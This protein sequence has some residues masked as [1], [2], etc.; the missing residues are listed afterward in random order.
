MSIQTSKKVAL[1]ILD[2]WGYR[3]EKKYNAIAQAKTPNWDS[4]LSQ[5]SF[6]L[7][8]ASGSSVG[9]PAGQMGNSEVGHMH[10][11]S[12]QIIPQDLCRINQACQSDEFE[13]LVS[14]HISNF[15]PKS[16]H[17]VGLYSDGGVH[18]HSK[19]WQVLID[20]LKN[21]DVYLHPILDGRDTAPKVAQKDL[22]VLTEHCLENPRHSLATIS[23]RFY[24]MDRDNR[25]ER[26]DRYAELFDSNMKASQQSADAYIKMNYKQGITDEFIEPKKLKSFECHQ[27]DLIITMNFRPDRMKQIVT[28]LK[29]KCSVLNMTDYGMALPVI[30]EKLAI[31]SCLGSIFEQ[32]LMTQIRV[33]E[34]EK[35]P[36]VTYFFNA[37][38]QTPF[39]KEQRVLIPSPKVKTYDESPEMSADSVCEAIM[40]AMSDGVN[41]IFANFANADM[42]GHT[43]DFEK[44]VIAVEVLDHCI[45]QLLKQAKKYDYQL[46]IT[47]D[48][49]NAEWMKRLENDQVITSHTCS[50]VPFVTNT[51]KKLKNKGGLSDIAPT[52]LEMM[53]VAIPDFWQGKSLLLND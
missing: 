50:A 28:K 39:K 38:R 53:G 46:V 13:K 27:D 49:G 20:A 11:G 22:G 4:L 51:N 47:A 1:I 40:S 25:W 18:S 41:G 14:K 29:D 8:S 10:I 5:H 3:K 12:G 9:L 32:E 33:A 7:L 21:Y 35:F 6:S 36:H 23:G 44:T 31:E 45:G 24:A 26:T 37:G 15:K 48:H 34:T 43:G 42:V 19:H 16:I 2:G 30:F 17:L 52:I